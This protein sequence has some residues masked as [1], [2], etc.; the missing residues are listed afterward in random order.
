MA[1]I[2]TTST[3]LATTLI[4]RGKMSAWS[5]RERYFSIC[6]GVVMLAVLSVS[7][8]MVPAYA[9]NQN[10]FPARISALEAQVQMLT[11]ETTS[12]KSQLSSQQATLAN[13]EVCAGN[14]AFYSPS[15]PAADSQGCVSLSNFSEFDAT[16][17]HTD[18]VDG[19]LVPSA[20]IDFT[21]VH[22]NPTHIK[23]GTQCVTL[24]KNGF[25]ISEVTIS[26]INDVAILHL[27]AC[28]NVGVSD[29]Q[30]SG[31]AN[32]KIVEIPEGAAFI[33]LNSR[34]Q[35][36]LRGAKS[37]RADLTVDVLGSI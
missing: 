28:F 35:K 26:D 37:N 19:F 4:R 20:T 15:N 30:S 11:S 17:L 27:R 34:F 29:S 36:V 25:S 21:Y 8:A 9:Q 16:V 1:V 22:G 31:M 24:G 14:L 18:S 3:N 2:A 6:C 23:I 12:I 10:S 33:K 7:V 32:D 5:M 13:W